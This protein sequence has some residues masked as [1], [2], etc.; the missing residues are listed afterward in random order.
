M[1]AA[2]FLVY[3]PNHGIGVELA[4]V[5]HAARLARLL[6]RTV[7][8]PLLPI[9]ETQEYQGGIEEYFEPPSGFDWISTREFCERYG[10][11]IHQL[12]SLLPEWQ[13]EYRSK[14]IRD[15]HPVW[16][17]NIHRHPYFEL[18]GMRVRE[19]TQLTITEPLEPAAAQAMFSADTPMLGF[20]YLH[21]LVP[22]NSTY[23]EPD[24]DPRWVEDVP[25]LPRAEF[26]RAAEL[27][28]GGRPNVA[29]HIRRG[30]LD[31]ARAIHGVE[32]PGVASF[33]AHVPSDAEL[34]YLATDVPSVRDEVR[35]TLPD[36]RQI[37]TGHVTRDA[38]LD[39]SAC[40]L[41]DQFVGTDYS[42]FTRY[43]LHARTNLGRSPNSTVLLATSPVSA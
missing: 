14:V 42:T 37:E 10:G 16:L 33:L 15:R 9:L 30:S 27:V 34:V 31:N 32:L 8:L 24:A 43:V 19:V 7:V 21:S 36:A 13:P 11:E 25:P 39:L 28:L 35:A 26:L 12:F 22:G 18:A 5:H 38:V 17:D 3:Q 4:M 1:A 23:E 20:S 40:V 6:D 41:A 29:M 2:G